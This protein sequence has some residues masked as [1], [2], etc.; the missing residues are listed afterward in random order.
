MK[1]VNRIKSNEDFALTIHKGKYFKLGAF[2]I[3][4]IRTDLDHTR[5]GISVSKKIG[6][7]V[8]RNRIKRQIR[9]MCDHSINFKNNVDIVIIVRTQFLE[10]NFQE[11]KT[12]LCEF[13]HKEHLGVS[14]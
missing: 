11:N 8:V 1:V 5:V 7:A 10:N 2:H 3:S 4:Y 14:E 12:I 9:A 13:L 6:K